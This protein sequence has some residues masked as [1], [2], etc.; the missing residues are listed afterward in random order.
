MIVVLD[1]SGW[2]EVRERERER[3]RERG[4]EGERERGRERGGVMMGSVGTGWSFAGVR[5][6]SVP[7]RGQRRAAQGGRGRRVAPSGSGSGSGSAAGVEAEEAVAAS[8]AGEEG[9]TGWRAARATFEDGTVVEPMRFEACEAGF[10]LKAR[11][12]LVKP[13][14]RIKKRSVLCFT[15][16]GEL[17]EVDAGG[18]AA[19]FGA[20]P[21]LPGLCQSLAA[22]AHD[23]RVT[24]VFVQL[25]PVAM[26]WAKV[27]EVRRH[28]HYFR[29]SGKWAACYLEVG[30]EKE[31]ALALGFDEAYAPPGAYLSVRGVSVSGSFLG[32]VLR[33]AGVQPQIQRIGK[34]KS[35]GDQLSRDD[36][37]AEQREQ[38][39]AILEDAYSEGLVRTLAVAAPGRAPADVEALLDACPTRAEAFAEAGWITGVKYLDEV[40]DML[41]ARNGDTDPGPVEGKGEES[42]KKRAKRAAKNARAELTG[43][44]YRKYRKAWSG[45]SLAYGT[46][47]PAKGKPKRI[48]VLRAAGAIG[49]KAG[50]GGSSG[51]SADNF[52]K[53]VMRLRKM[54]AR[55]PEG[56]KPFA[57]CVLRVDSPGGDALASDLMWRQLRLLA[58]EMPVIA[59]MGDVAASGGYYMAMG[60]DAI[61][62]E[63][64]TLTGSIGVVTGKFN[65]AGL[66]ER[67]GFTKETLSKGRYAELQVD[68]RGFTDD[69]ASLF[70]RSAQDAY[71]SFRDKAALSRG[72]SV[73]A[74]QEVAQGRVWTGKA[75]SGIGLVDRI[76][77]V[78]TAVA[79][80]KER[81]GIPADE[82]VVP[83]ELSFRRQ[84]LA[85]ALSP[86]GASIVVALGGGLPALA[87][88]VA[89]EALCRLAA[90]TALATQVEG[91]LAEVDAGLGPASSGRLPPPSLRML[92]VE[93]L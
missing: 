24:G 1:L 2:V 3:E 60:C 68:N 91:L 70:E 63:G 15:L 82:R 11:R 84:G 37:S 39:G 62:A 33:K 49:R 74:M 67:V 32:G 78:G 83:V 6:A 87:V 44:P 81:A 75:A 27:E 71:A 21:T 55:A 72:M 7:G 5:G 20:R 12:A 14:R 73:D 76:G 65:L 4:R 86:G 18:L 52:I 58:K 35:A 88:A 31:L 90:G 77:G 80:A 64:L 40:L 79:L 59:S 51:I 26:G 93:R 48:A 17:P 23:P 34:Y 22:A 54:S 47:K 30:G 46:A 43:V 41:K 10:G 9:V 16:G 28:L 19:S 66:Y 53:E 45:P 25:E 61:V 57:A 8:A 92:D 38:L 89:F 13:W 56:K 36:M 50:S 29:Q 85:S 42:D 69:E